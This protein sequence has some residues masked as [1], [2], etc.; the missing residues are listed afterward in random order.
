MKI[1][2]RTF[3]QSATAATAAGVLA[4]VEGFGG[5]VKKPTIYV[6]HGE[7]AKKMLL[8]GV[9]KLGGFDKLVKKGGKVTLKP[10][11]AWASRPEQ[12]GNTS[13]DLVG[14]CVKACKAAGAKQVVV[15]ENTCSPARKAFSLSGV[16]AAVKAAGGEMYS[17]ED[18]KHFREVKIP[19]GKELKET[20]VAI[21]VMDT[22]LLINMPVAKSH[23]GCTITASLKNWMGSVKNR[24]TWHMKG[25]HQCVA[26]VNTVIRADLIVV[27]ATRIM[28]TDGPRGPGNVEH[29]K[30]LIVGTDPV[31]IDAYAATLFKLKPFD[32]EHIKIAHDMKLGVGDLDQVEVVHIEV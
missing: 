16:E 4:P 20:D 27:D 13:P 17:A 23:S 31:A 26:D 12:G 5:A 22:D 21:D 25:V 29:P 19:N 3:I 6:I 10:N 1:D 28:T 7:D 18:R 11:A 15:P 30:Q 32:V 8:A 2:R 24:K 14:A 9:G